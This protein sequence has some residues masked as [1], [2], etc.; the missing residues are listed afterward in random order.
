MLPVTDD[1][2]T[3]ALAL[4]RLDG[5]GR[6]TGHR[7]VERFDGPGDLRD[8]SR[9]QVFLRLKGLPNAE[10]ITRRLFETD[11]LDDALDEAR[12]SIEAL[13]ERGVKLLSPRSEA[14][15]G[16]LS[17]LAPAERPLLLWAYGRAEVLERPSAALLARPP[18]EEAPF[19]RA[20][21]L[22]QHL[23]AA[24]A[25]PVLGGQS[26]FDVALAKRAA[27]ECAP[28]A[29]VAACGLAEVPP[30]LRPVAGRAVRAGGVLLSPFPM[31]HGPFDH[32]DAERAR[33]QTALARAAVFAP[34]A[35]DTPEAR[36]LTWAA[37]AG[38]PAFVL[39]S[40]DD[41]PE[42]ARPVRG[43]DDFDAVRDC[44]MRGT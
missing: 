34:P 25:V 23:T 22:A 11:E 4:T 31:T 37:E 42:N 33:V 29:L 28:V 38:R 3:F 10:E 14:W 40:G 17:A 43:P 2:A 21:A 26:G 7:L 16:G 44:V 15:P 36:A 41:V 18:M 39:G 20:Q 1:A 30:R 6:V 27:G 24:G 13:S 9:E 12:A 35:P 8:H 32:D 19:E 5:V